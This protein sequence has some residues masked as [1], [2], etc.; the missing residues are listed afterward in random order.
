MSPAVQPY[1]PAQFARHLNQSAPLMALKALC[2]EKGIPLYLVGGAVRDLLL[3]DTLSPDLDVVVPAEAAKDVAESLARQ[4][5]GKC[6]CLDAHFQIYRVIVFPSLDMLDIAGCIGD[7]IEADLQRRDL[8]V[9]A[10]GYDFATGQL[11]DPINGQVDLA[12]GVIRMLRAGNM[13]EDPLRLLR[14]FRIAAELGF[15][16]IDAATL[17]VVRR[18]GEK[19]IKV[20]AERINYEMMKLLSAPRCYYHVRLMAETRL[21]EHIYPELTPSHQSP[22]NRYHHLGLFDHTLEL[23]NQSELHFSSLPQ[24]IQNHLKS[25]FNPFTKRLALVRLACLFH[26]IG[27]PPTMQY[28]PEQDKYMYYG[29]DAVS[30]ELVLGIAVRLKWGKDI[31]KDVY[32][33]VRWHLYPGDML[34]PAVTDKGLRKFF[35]R[36]GPILPE[37][38]LL[39]IADR[40]SACGPAITEADLTDMKAGLIA[41]WDKYKAYKIAVEAKPKLL[42]GKE[43]MDL[44][45][46]EPGPEVGRIMAEISEAQ[47]NGELSSREAAITWLLQARG[48]AN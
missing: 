46:I 20:A 43:I 12:N 6:I 26:D 16:N 45:H 24:E 28:D 48:K 1:N 5:D 8:T 10:I 2:D 22:A 4:I 23:I 21:L 17:E 11:L 38:L 42:T 19:V 25:D 30:A 32:E 37:L 31:T 47:T 34:K 35:N 27:K 14:V 9:N 13:V 29:H 15:E 18:H 7:S 3:Q 41:L 39:A 36:V 33:L 40:Y 44:L